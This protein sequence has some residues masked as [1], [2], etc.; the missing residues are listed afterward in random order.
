MKIHPVGGRLFHMG[1]QTG[2][3]KPRVTFHNFVNTHKKLLL[4]NKK[5]NMD[6]TI[7]KIPQQYLK[8]SNSWE[9]KFK[10]HN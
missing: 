2:M 1:R 4:H 6:V 8:A 3:M 10:C 5:N 9:V 7:L